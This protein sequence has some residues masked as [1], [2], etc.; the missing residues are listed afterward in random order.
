[1]ALR[2]IG[3]FWYI[4]YRDVAQKVRTIA[5][6]ETNKAKAAVKDRL[7]MAQLAAE[8]K[9]RKYAANPSPTTISTFKIL[10]F[11][12]LYHKT[13]LLCARNFRLLA[14]FQFEVFTVPES[15]CLPA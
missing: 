4:Y 1:M 2:K 8:K 12:G 15:I 6:A 14:D 13:Q 5:T 7:W 10:L 3:Q 11:E 9:S